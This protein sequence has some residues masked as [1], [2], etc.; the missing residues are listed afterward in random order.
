MEE[1]VKTFG[2]PDVVF[3]DPPRKGMTEKVISDIAASG[4]KKVVYISCN[5]STLA[6][7]IKIFAEKGY[8]VQ[9]AA[10]FDLFPRTSHVESVVCL[11]RSDKAT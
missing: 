11:T 4:T 1:C 10:V 9:N 5:P 8:T 3:T 7:D 6:R 2:T